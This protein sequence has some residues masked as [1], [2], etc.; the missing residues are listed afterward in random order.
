MAQATQS[1]SVTQRTINC[2][3]CLSHVLCI[4]DIIV[5]GKVITTKGKTSCSQQLRPQKKSTQLF[6][7]PPHF[8]NPSFKMKFLGDFVK[9]L[10][11]FLGNFRVI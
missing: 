4:L 9:N 5:L 1:G 7:N 10:V 8:G 11:S 3:M 6:V 2:T